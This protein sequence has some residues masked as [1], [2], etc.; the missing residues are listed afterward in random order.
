MPTITVKPKAYELYTKIRMSSTTI[1]WATVGMTQMMLTSWSRCTIFG[2]RARAAPDAKCTNVAWSKDKCDLYYRNYCTMQCNLSSDGTS[3]ECSKSTRIITFGE[4]AA[5]S[6]G[7]CESR[8]GS[9]RVGR[10]VRKAAI[11]MWESRGRQSA[12]LAAV[13]DANPVRRRLCQVARARVSAPQRRGR[14]GQT[15]AAPRPAANATNVLG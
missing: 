13:P 4:T 15:Y 6:V 14:S 5:T 10:R 2:P 1:P 11:G 7:A 3:K 12:V 8:N 9:L